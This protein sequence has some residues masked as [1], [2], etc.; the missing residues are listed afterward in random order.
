[1]QRLLPYIL[2]IVIIQLMGCKKEQVTDTGFFSNYD[3]RDFRMGFTTW[4]Y[5]RT[6]DAVDSTYLFINDHA[7]I[8]SE[9]LDYR[10]P[11]K[12]WMNDLPLPADYVNNIQSRANRKIIGKKL[13]LSVSLLNTERNDLALDYDDT[14][15]DYI[16]MNDKPIED[17]YFKHVNYLVENLDPDYLVIAVEVNNL[18]TAGD[19][20]WDE[21]KAL[22]GN[23]K[24][25]IKQEYPGLKI[26]ESV[27][28]HEMLKPETGQQ[29]YLAELFN[30]ID[31]MDFA[32]I[33]YYPFSNNYHTKAEFQTAFDLINQHVNVPIAFVETAH[34]AQNLVVPALQVNIPGSEAEQQLYLETLCNNAQEHDYEFII[35]WGHRDYTALW[36]TLPDYIKDLAM[37]WLHT[38]IVRDDGSQRAAYHSWQSVYEKQFRQ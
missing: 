10:I 1:M 20:K 33:S 35:W 34:I 18:L 13:L 28:L 14:R 21:Y 36:Q 2:T 8:Y 9:H 24:T 23:V 30:Y 6:I 19:N 27:M 16:H 4:P 31:Q 26:S 22:I 5:A 37:F 32:S 15:P 25:R 17:A 29:Q 11:W 7:D 38:G 12:A 3:Q